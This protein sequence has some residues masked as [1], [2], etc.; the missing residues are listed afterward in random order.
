LADFGVLGKLNLGLLLFSGVAKESLRLRVEIGVLLF[1]ASF[2][3]DLDTFNRGLLLN[4]GVLV[5]FGVP[6]EAFRLLPDFWFLDFEADVLRDFLD[7]LLLGD[8]VFFCLEPD[9]GDL[10]LEADL[11]RDF[12]VECGLIFGLLL[13]SGVVFNEGV[14]FEEDFPFEADSDCLFPLGVLGVPL[15]V[16]FLL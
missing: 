12:F 13:F 5:V 1:E 11:F 10:L 3:S 4:F 14:F 6:T 16:D 2:V 8:T 7:V 15:W 9:F